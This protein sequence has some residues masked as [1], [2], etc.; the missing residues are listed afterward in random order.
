MIGEKRDCMYMF[1]A[2]D[3]YLLVVKSKDWMIIIMSG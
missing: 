1:C 3:S 2:V